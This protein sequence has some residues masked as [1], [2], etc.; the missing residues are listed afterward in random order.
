MRSMIRNVLCLSEWSFSQRSAGGGVL[1]RISQTADRPAEDPPERLLHLHTSRQ[2]MALEGENGGAALQ[3]DHPHLPL[4][5]VR[6]TWH[7]T[8][9]RHTGDI[10]QMTSYGW[11]HSGKANTAYTII[12]FIYVYI[13]AYMHRSCIHVQMTNQH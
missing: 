13:Y 9:E 4:V 11:H 1:R 2:E 7:H 3:P 12:L 6:L 8:G 5:Q 10:I